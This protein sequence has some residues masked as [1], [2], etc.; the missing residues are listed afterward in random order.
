MSD[1]VPVA[2]GLVLE[3]SVWLSNLLA[4][5]VGPSWP[6]VGWPFYPPFSV[7]IEKSQLLMG[8]DQNK[9]ISQPALPFS[10]SRSNMDNLQILPETRS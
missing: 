5:V 3:V 2:R 7:M 10:M 1:L 8:C 4:L 6:S 9:D